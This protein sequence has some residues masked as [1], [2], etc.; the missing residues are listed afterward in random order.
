MLTNQ[1]IVIIGGS[2]GIGYET[3]KKAIEQG[4][5]VI[6]ASRS[7]SKLQK[8]TERLGPKAEA[9]VL[10]TAYEEQV[11]AFFENIGPFDH[12]VVTAAVSSGGPFLHTDNQAARELFESKFWGQLYAAKAFCISCRTALS[13]VRCFMSKADICYHNKAIGK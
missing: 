8:A 6:I 13:R 7:A 3:A 2:S 10:N 1:K 9:L 4:A 5:E 12:L 11:K